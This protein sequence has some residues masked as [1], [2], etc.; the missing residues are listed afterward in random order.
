[1]KNLKEILNKKGL[2]KDQQ[3]LTT[4]AH[5]INVKTDFPV[6]SFSIINKETKFYILFFYIYK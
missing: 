3:P 6:P 5:S 4:F 2:E 1:M